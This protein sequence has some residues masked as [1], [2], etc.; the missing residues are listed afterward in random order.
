MFLIVKNGIKMTGMPGFGPTHSD[1]EVWAMV[2]FLKRLRTISP[3]EYATFTKA[4]DNAD[5][6]ENHHH[7]EENEP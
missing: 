4:K 1:S 3:E 6:H 2:A 5:E 7:H